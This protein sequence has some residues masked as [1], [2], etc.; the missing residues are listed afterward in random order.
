MKQLC[1]SLAIVLLLI[2]AAFINVC[3]LRHFVAELSSVLTSAQSLAEQ[4]DP[5]EAESLSHSV[6][7]TFESH[8][9]Y[10][11]VT[12][13]HRDIDDI[14][15]AFGEVLEY[16]SLGETG[17]LYAS[18]NARLLTLLQLLLESEQL[19]LKNIL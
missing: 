6:H 2:T 13:T 15:T 4:G 9:F 8:S 7:E 17:P 11:H 16:L 5:K 3:Y 1:C 12:L 10:L 14:E 19:N 18:A